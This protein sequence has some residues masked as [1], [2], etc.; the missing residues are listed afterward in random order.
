MAFT[1]V[2]VN[3]RKVLIYVR[4]YKVSAHS[5][6]TAI[7]WEERLSIVEEVSNLLLALSFLLKG[8]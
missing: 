4:Q 5:A 7:L 8:I 3:F 6:I 2:I 1:D